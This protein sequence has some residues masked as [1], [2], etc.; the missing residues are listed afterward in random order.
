MGGLWL[1][2]LMVAIYHLKPLGIYHFLRPPWEGCW[3]LRHWRNHF[4]S[5]KNSPGLLGLNWNSGRNHW[6]YSYFRNSWNQRNLLHWW[7]P[8]IIGTFILSQLGLVFPIGHWL[9]SGKNF[10]GKKEGLTVLGRPG[11]H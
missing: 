7:F 6:N 1:K 11:N 5:L 4:G 8:G 2:D 9:Y 10:P 3:L